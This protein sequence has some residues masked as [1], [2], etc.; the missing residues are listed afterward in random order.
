VDSFSN[1]YLRKDCIGVAES[2]VDKLEDIPLQDAPIPKVMQTA[3]NIC[4]RVHD[5]MAKSATPEAAHAAAEMAKHVQIKAD[6]RL[7]TAV[8]RYLFARVGPTIWNYYTSEHSTVDVTYF[9]KREAVREIADLK[10][11]KDLAVHPS[12]FSKT[13]TYA[14]QPPFHNSQEAPQAD[15]DRSMVTNSSLMFRRAVTSLSR[16]E[17]LLSGGLGST[18][19]E[20]VEALAIAHC[21]MKACA[22][23]ASHGNND[24]SS[25]DDILPIFIF[26]LIR[27]SI[28]KPSA[29]ASLMSDT[30]TAEERKSEEGQIVTLMGAAARYVSNTWKIEQV[31]GNI[32]EA[33]A[34]SPTH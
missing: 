33:V 4:E 31:T 18:P 13:L 11:L 14:T 21:E 19:W 22:L 2:N 5:M 12:F 26:I 32:E 17:V 16:V 1:S 30:L 7:R 6:T 9:Q 8:E 20:A 10:I 29:C 34:D 28:S 23:E 25:M 15:V 3:G 27:S 24:L